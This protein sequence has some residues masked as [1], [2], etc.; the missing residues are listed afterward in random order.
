GEAVILV[1]GAPPAEPGAVELDQMLGV[2][3][4]HLP[5]SSAAAAAASLCGVRRAD[6]YARALALTKD[7]GGEV[8]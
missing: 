8:T 4:R 5:P 2:L 7:P 6:A 1:E 3:L